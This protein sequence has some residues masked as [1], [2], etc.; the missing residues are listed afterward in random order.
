MNRDDAQ[1]ILLLYRPGM[2]DAADPQIAE[3]LALAKQDAELA[4]WLDEHCRRQ[5]IL[6][7]KFRHIPVPAG[8]RE[9]IISE[10]AAQEKIIVW[11]RHP[12]LTAVAAILVIL[13]ALAAVRW[14]LARPDHADNTLAIYRSRMVGVALR[15]YA[16]DLA[17]KDPGQIRAFLKQNHAP[18]DYVLPA[19]LGNVA[20]TGCAIESWQGV[21][22]SLIC[23]RAGKSLPAGQ[24]GDLWLFVVDRASVK[25]APSAPRPQL[26]R[27]NQLMTATWSQGDTLYL[28][29]TAGDEQTIRRLL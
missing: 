20:L 27:V 15:G 9:Q 26:A 22:V 10:H 7:A 2:A 24:P 4:R 29:G 8:L 5:E 6:R 12:A 21:K 17:T 3:A 23:F 25:N 14:Q 1:N 16:M 19:P 18:A 28:L 13:F 11:W